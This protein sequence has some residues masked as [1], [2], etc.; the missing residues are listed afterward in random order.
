MDNN[1]MALKTSDGLFELIGSPL[2][3]V[4]YGCTS[5]TLLS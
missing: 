1:A 3:D 2:V 4:V 5:K